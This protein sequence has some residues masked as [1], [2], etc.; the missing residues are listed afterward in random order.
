MCPRDSILSTTPSTTPSTIPNSD[1]FSC[2]HRAIMNEDISMLEHLANDTTAMVRRREVLQLILDYSVLTGKINAAEWALT[3]RTRVQE[4]TILSSLE[5]GNPDII[6]WVLNRTRYPNWGKIFKRLE[7][8]R[9]LDTSYPGARTLIKR[10][11]ELLRYAN[12]TLQ[13][14]L[15]Q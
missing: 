3:H 15:T 9:Y 7:N 8:S 14:N 1:R 6:E 4:S 13:H 10:H 5:K 11:P 2:I 12:T